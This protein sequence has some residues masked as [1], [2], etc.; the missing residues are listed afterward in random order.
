MGLGG[1]L[2]VLGEDDKASATLFAFPTRHRACPAA[3]QASFETPTGLHP[4]LHISLP[5]GAATTPDIGKMEEGAVARCGLH[6]YLTLPSALFIDRHAFSDPLFLASQGL[7]GLK[8]FSGAMDLEAPDWSVKAWGSTALFELRGGDGET[9]PADATTD[10]GLR[11]TIPLHLRYLSPSNSSSAAAPPETKR[12]GTTPARS[13]ITALTVP[14]PA[15]FW[16]CTPLSTSPGKDPTINPFDRLHLGYNDL[17][18]VGTVFYHIPP[19]P[20][21]ATT[22]TSSSSVM[23][24]LQVPVLNLS[25]QQHSLFSAAGIEFGTVGAILVGVGWVLW[26]LFRPVGGAGGIGDGDG[27]KRGSKVKSG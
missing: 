8:A 7:K 1:F 11:A 21:N 10:T 19:T 16:A 6:A 27:K 15:V 18:P 25:P 13:G 23:L 12:D 17:F 24:D 9:S 22:S 26:C 14:P 4:T 20:S 3:F 2:T 5:K